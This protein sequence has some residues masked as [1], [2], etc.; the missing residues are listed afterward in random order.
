MK[1]LIKL[2][3]WT[4]KN[5][6]LRMNMKTTY[7]IFIIALLL[8]AQSCNTKVETALPNQE[9]VLSVEAALVFKSGDVKPVARTE[10]F[11]LNKSFDTILAESG[12]MSSI[13]A[14]SLPQRIKDNFSNMN[15]I[16]PV[17]TFAVAV[18]VSEN[19][20]TL[21]LPLAKVINDTKSH[22]AY[23]T[24]TDF[25]GKAQFKDIKAG[26]YFLFGYTKV[27][28]SVAVWNLKTEVKSGQNTITLDQKNALTS[29]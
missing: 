22:I 11:L 29:D 19:I 23:S 26:E 25:Q 24:T 13:S 16:N 17:K 9:N 21:Q 3:F 10:F 12:F 1:L 14:S 28:E 8:F 27:G 7:L 5:K 6:I 4:Q 18:N 15:K 20:E 2:N